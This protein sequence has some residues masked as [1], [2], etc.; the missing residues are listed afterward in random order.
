MM[1]N[2]QEWIDEGNG[3]LALGEL[4]KA[5]ECYQKA[6]ELEPE[7]FDAWQ[8]IC[9]VLIKLNRAAEAIE[10]GQRAIELRPNDQMAYA[11]MSLAY[12]RNHQIKEAEAMGA[13]ARI[14][15]WG[16]KVVPEGKAPGGEGT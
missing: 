14:I 7:C 9:V 8:A 5:L 11:T 1:M 12:G 16:G 2:A 15:S 4:D 13:K 10:A 3:E 6:T